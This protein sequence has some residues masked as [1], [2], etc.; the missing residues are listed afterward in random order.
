MTRAAKRVSETPS[1]TICPRTQSQNRDTFDEHTKFPLLTNSDDAI[2]EQK[3]DFESFPLDIVNVILDILYDDHDKATVICLGLTCRSYWNYVQG[4]PWTYFRF[5]KT[6]DQLVLREYLAAFIET[7]IGPNYRRLGPD[8]RHIQTPFLSRAV[9]GNFP[10]AKEKTLDDR[11]K[12]YKALVIR[13][14]DEDI[15]FVPKPLGLSAE[16]WFPLA[17]RE[18]KKHILRWGVPNDK[19]AA[20]YRKYRASCLCRWLMFNGGDK[21]LLSNRDH[22][23]YGKY[24]QFSLNPLLA[25]LMAF[26]DDGKSWPMK[27]KKSIKKIQG[28]NAKKKKKASK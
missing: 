13:E 7:W 16:Q 22:V 25:V 5:H 18:L 23:A 11:W 19:K 14:E 12:D 24:F 2:S 6:E 3:S 1:L 15:H 4:K 9:Y 20:V 27:S 17:A 10:G 26:P 8:S 28:E 21:W